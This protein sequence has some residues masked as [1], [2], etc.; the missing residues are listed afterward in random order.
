MG[1]SHR[2][3]RGCRRPRTGLASSPARCRAKTSMRRSSTS[4]EVLEGAGGPGPGSLATAPDRSPR[5]GVRRMRLV[6]LRSCRGTHLQAR[7]LP[8]DDGADRWRRGIRL[9]RTPDRG[10]RSRVS[11][12]Q[13]LSRLGTERFCP[14]RLLRAGHARRDVRRGLRGAVRADA[15]SPSEARGGHRQRAA[16]PSSRSRRSRASTLDT[17][18]RG[19][20]CRPAPSAVTPTRC[21]TRCSTSSTESRSRIRKA[22]FSRGEESAGSGSRSGA[23]STP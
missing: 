9:R 8:G 11:P 10:I 20:R 19:R 16:R 15:R 23:A 17:G 4:K 14:H 6:A 5:G 3:A 13:P 12:A 18:W 7:A 1:T 21:S 2:L 22:T